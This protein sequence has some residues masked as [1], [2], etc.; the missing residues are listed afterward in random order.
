[1]L[2]LSWQTPNYILVNTD[3]LIPSSIILAGVL[4]VYYGSIATNGFKLTVRMGYIYMGVYALYA[5]Y[6]IFLVWLVD[7]YGLNDKSTL[8]K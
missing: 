8:R 4:V 1:L 3:E 5:L 2:Y 7:I 6:S